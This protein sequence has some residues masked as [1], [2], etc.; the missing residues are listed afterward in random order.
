MKICIAGKNDIACN[1]LKYLIEEIN[2]NKE[3]IVV[4]PNKTDEGINK[5]QKSLKRIAIDN[6]INVISDIDK[7]YNIE[8]LIFISL[9]YD[10]IID[11]NLFKSKKLYN[12]H[13]SKL[14]SYKGMY[15]SAWPILNGEN[16]S[17]VT[18]HKIDNG[19]D[20]GDIIDQLEFKIDINWTCRDLYFTYLKEGFNLFKRNIENILD[21]NL[22]F[23]EQGSVN[24]TYYSKNSIDYNNLVIDLNKTA[25]EIY[26]NIRAFIFFEYQL[27]IIEG[28]K[29]VSVKL[30]DYRMT[31]KDKIVLEE[32]TIFIKGIDN[33]GVACNIFEE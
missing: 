20:T 16:Y 13:F 1:S 9:E 29:I 6:N 30:L 7:L 32:N 19:I 23:T 3:D 31:Q 11:V 27:P 15:T 12:I 5:W 25:F 4:L 10:K 17:G 21:D 24:S 33:Y 28:Y 26:N 2:I 8:D 18:L 14:P 22:R